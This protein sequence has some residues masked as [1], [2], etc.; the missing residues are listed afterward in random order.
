MNVCRLFSYVI[1]VFWLIIL[2]KLRNNCIPHYTATTKCPPYTMPI[3]K[4]STPKETI[5][6]DNYCCKISM[7][8]IECDVPESELHITGELYFVLNACCILSSL[9][10]S[11]ILAPLFYSDSL[12]I[13]SIRHGAIFCFSCCAIWLVA[14]VVLVEPNLC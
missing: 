6:N 5:D 1:I 7:R 9:C 2:I 12:Y 3:S 4:I 14:R 10:I 11:V 8:N 13:R